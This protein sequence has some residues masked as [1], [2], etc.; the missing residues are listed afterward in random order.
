MSYPPHHHL[1]RD[2]PFEIEDT[3]PESSRAHLR[4]APELLIGADGPLGIGPVLVAADVVSGFLVGRVIAPDWMATSQIAVHLVDAP[5]PVGSVS[6]DVAVRRAGRTTV[7]VV[8]DIVDGDSG[9]PAGDGVLTFVRLPRRDG[10]IEIPDTPVVVG[11]RSSMTLPGSGFT[12]RYREEIGI[13][14]LDPASGSARMQVSEYVRNSFGAVNGGVVTSL[15][16]EAAAAMAGPRLGR[17]AR[18]LD[19]TAT[20]LSQGKVGPLV[21]RS[22]PLRTDDRTALVRVEVTDEGS[23]S[24]DDPGGRVLVIAHVHCGAVTD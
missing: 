3:G 8:A 14:V 20:Y 17:P 19:L 12:R 24:D 10:N 4:V 15:A 7:V 13:E 11:T 21:A 23:A 22:R 2:L 16:A 9:A 5:A 1:L 18:P 6:I